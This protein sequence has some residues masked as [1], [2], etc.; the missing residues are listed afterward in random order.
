[1]VD[2]DLEMAF[3]TELLGAKAELDEAPHAKA[4]AAANKVLRLN[5]MVLVG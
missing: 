3:P 2:A 5:I 1:M 4:A